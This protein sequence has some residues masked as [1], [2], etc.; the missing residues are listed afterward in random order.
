[1]PL[2]SLDIVLVKDAKRKTCAQL[3]QDKKIERT[4]EKGG[5]RGGGEG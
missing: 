3:Q 2:H 4:R 5:K 1:M